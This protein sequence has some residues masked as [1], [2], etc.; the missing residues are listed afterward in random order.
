MLVVDSLPQGPEKS[1]APLLGHH[2]IH[3]Y[4]S[5]QFEAGQLSCYNILKAYSLLDQ[6]VGYC[7]GLSSMVGIMLLHVSEEKEFKMLKFLM[8]DM[9]FWK[10]YQLDMVILQIQMFQLSQL[11]HNYHPDHYDH[12]EEPEIRP[13]L[14]AALRFLMVF[15]SQFPLGLVARVFDVIFLQGPEVAHGK[16]L[17]LDAMVEK[18]LASE[19]KLKQATLALDLERATLLQM[20]E[21]L[22]RQ[23]VELS[24]GQPEP[25]GD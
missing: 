3:P 5:A 8:F 2:T 24:A 19:S 17:S 11:L 10:Q 15:L 20:V 14:Y 18:L 12:L 7:H 1:F 25:T 6:E 4:F 22:R 23:P 9:G 21:E 13:S 16:I